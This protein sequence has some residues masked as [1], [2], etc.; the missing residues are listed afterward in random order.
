MPVNI[1]EVTAEVESGASPAAQ[2]PQA[3]PP[4]EQTSLEER[5]RLAESRAQ[6]VRA[7]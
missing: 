1:D 5:L 2:E 3:S 6:R 4:R 7:D